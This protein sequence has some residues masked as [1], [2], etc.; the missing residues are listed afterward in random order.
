MVLALNMM[1]EVRANGGT[2][3]VN[4]LEELL[5]IPVVP[6]SAAKKRRHRRTDRPCHPCGA[7][8]R[9]A[10]RIDFCEGGDQDGDENG[11]VHRCI[12]AVVH[13]IEDHARRAG[14]AD[15]L[16][17][18]QAR[19]GDPL[20]LK[21]LDLEPNEQDLLE[22][23][24]TQMETEGGLDREA[25]LADM[26]FTFIEKL[27]AETVVHPAESREHKRSVAIDRI[28]TGKY[29]ALP[30]FIGILALVFWMTFGAIGAFLSDLLTMGID[31][32]T[33]VVDSALTA[34][35]INPVVHSLVIDVSLPAWAAF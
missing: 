3:L 23:A 16:C 17:R 22:H 4:R 10:R 26:R 13:L 19:G 6:I 24:V 30:C 35:G 14:L 32:L 2:I 7:L 5:G 25:A 21:A 27:C 28:L 20:I 1:D 11:A 15:A 33:G 31:A 12:H 18:H 8:P 9:D 34:Y 29:T